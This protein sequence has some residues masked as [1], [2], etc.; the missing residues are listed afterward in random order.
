VVGLALAASWFGMWGLYATYTWT[1]N[2]GA[3][4]LQVVRFYVPALGAIALLGA[5]FLV[6]LGTWLTARA[7]RRAPLTLVSTVL[8]VVTF[9]LGAWSFTG[10]RD[11][12]LG[13]V[14]V[15]HGA[16][17]PVINTNAGELGADESGARELGGAS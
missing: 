10:M 11:F 16:P 12:S 17:Q 13:G 4:S 8:V 9:G 15:V 1:A 2:P 7:P 6:R 5:W 14:H 3:S